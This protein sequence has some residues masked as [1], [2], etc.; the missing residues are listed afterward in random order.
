MLYQ[1]ATMKFENKHFYCLLS[2]LTVLNDFVY[3]SIWM[4]KFHQSSIELGWIF[5]NRLT[6]ALVLQKGQSLLY[7]NRTTFL[8][9]LLMLLSFVYIPEYRLYM[10][11]LRFS[12]DLNMSTSN[13]A[14]LHAYM[15]Q[16]T[17]KTGRIVFLTFTWISFSVSVRTAVAASQSW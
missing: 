8:N 4:S 9:N 13:C 3:N 12:P 5:Y 6:R 15:I 14:T 1:N 17:F 7:A 11:H 10:D 2:I 16:I